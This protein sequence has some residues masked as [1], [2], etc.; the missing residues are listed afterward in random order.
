MYVGCPE[1]MD[2]NHRAENDPGSEGNLGTSTE[3]LIC[4]F[5]LFSCPIASVR[6]GIASGKSKSSVD[7]YAV[8]IEVQ[9]VIARHM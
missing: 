9:R 1:Y 7:I 6:Q 4:S 3:Y 2:Y 8:H 5:V